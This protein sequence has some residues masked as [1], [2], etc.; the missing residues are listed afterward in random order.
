MSTLVRIGTAA[1]LATLGVLQW[2][3]GTAWL[4]SWLGNLGGRFDLDAVQSL[5]IVVGLEWTAA[6]L[7]LLLRG[8]RGI[9]TAWIAGL[10]V[11]FVALAEL[12]ALNAPG[13]AGGGAGALLLPALALLSGILVVVLATR[14]RAPDAP[15]QALTTVAMLGIASF[16]VCLAIAARLPIEH[17]AKTEAFA[18][19][20]LEAVDLAF[21]GWN[22]RTFADAGVA[23]H[24]PL[25][26]PETL[27]GDSI[28]VFY[29]PNCSHCHEVF[30]R[31]LAKGR[32]EKVIA[33]L[34]PPA[35]GAV[36]AQGDGEVGDIHCP[37]CIRLSLPQG[38][39]WLITT[40]SVAVVK[41]GVVRCTADKDF[42]ACL[43]APPEP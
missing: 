37:D 22:G 2:Q 32:P 36:E 23:R 41:D 3:G 7:V 11:A 18:N 38:P 27:E 13:A 17:T 12:G 42:T 35:D 1:L 15:R 9:T 21:E 33:V 10:A 30:D 4:P 29:N 34:V 20:G 6:A 26:T 19:Q 39:A 14:A 8:S 25:L 16:T 28:V 31:W 5:R 24:L 40:P 43:G